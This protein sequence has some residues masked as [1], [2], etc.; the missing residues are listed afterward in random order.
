MTKQEIKKLQAKTNHQLTVDD[1]DLIESLD[2]AARDVS[3]TTKR[4]SRILSQP[5]DLCGIPFYPLTVAKSLWYLEK[6]EEW[7][8]RESDYEGF[9]LWSLTL[10]NTPEALDSFTTKKEADRALRKMS[11][12]LHCSQHEISEVYLKCVGGTAAGE[13]GVGSDGADHTVDYGGIIAILLREYGGPVD[14]WLYETPVEMIGVL[15][16]ALEDRVED[17]ESQVRTANAKAGKA[18]APKP[19]K[20]L[21]SLSRF[22]NLANKIEALWSETD[23]K[24]EG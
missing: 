17:E 19:S 14:K 11:R 18:V 15:F 8:V 5:F 2:E 23:E 9:L 4:E 12:K 10:P 3:G 20:R 1:L 7:G 22:R 13:T 16:R 24:Q 21:A 6:V